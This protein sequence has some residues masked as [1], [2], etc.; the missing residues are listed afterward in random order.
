M[1]HEW[2]IIGLIISI[3]KAILMRAFL[4]PVTRIINAI[5]GG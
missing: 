4:W 3:P 5:F 2:D 1:K